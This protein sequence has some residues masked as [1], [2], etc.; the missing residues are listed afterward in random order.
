MNNL[1]TQYRVENDPHRFLGRCQREINF[2]ND[3]EFKVFNV[4][5]D[6]DPWK[7]LRK[8][9][10]TSDYINNLRINKSNIIDGNYEGPQYQPM[11]RGRQLKRPIL[12]Q[13]R[14]SGKHFEDG[15]FVI[16]RRLPHLGATIDGIGSDFVVVIKCP[17]TE[18]RWNELMNPKQPKV[19][20]SKM[21][22]Q[23]MLTNTP[24][25]LLVV[26]HPNFRSNQIIEQIDF[27]YDAEAAEKLRVEAENFWCNEIFSCL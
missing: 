25:T 7:M 5:R 24:K 15:G 19:L 18:K 21:L 20:R 23:M 10:I 2:E 6:S 17:T 16:N 13:L 26:A 11:L 27:L 4:E 9:R 8:G 1:L 12:D 22:A 3:A 14:R